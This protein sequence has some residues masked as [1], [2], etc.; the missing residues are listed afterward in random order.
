MRLG[1]K[2]IV[3]NKFNLNLLRCVTQLQ[4]KKFLLHKSVQVPYKNNNSN[5][6]LPS[7]T[8]YYC[9]KHLNEP[10]VNFYIFCVVYVIFLMKLTSN[11]FDVD[12]YYSHIFISIK[13]FLLQ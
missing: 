2:R 3:I 5:Q 8:N 4:K 1:F 7:I 6:F 13:Y 10:I 12:N 9:Y 11:M